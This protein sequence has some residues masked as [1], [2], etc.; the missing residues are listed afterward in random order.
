MSSQGPNSPTL[1]EDI[2]GIGTVSWGAPTNIYSSDN[3][4]ASASAI[5]AT[6]TTH[7]LRAT[8]FDFSIPDGSTIDGIT[9]EI[10]RKSVYGKDVAVNLVIGGS[11]V[12][13]N[14]ADTVNAWPV[15]YTYKQYG[16]ATDKWG[17]TPTVSQINAADFG[18]V[19]SAKVT[20]DKSKRYIYV[21]HIRITVN[22]TPVSYQ[23]RHGV[24]LYQDPGV[25]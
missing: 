17:L 25:V 19:L 15:S 22:Y 11:I 24:I 7:Y 12:G 4:P 13:S 23:P 8:D 6:L 21:D 14:Y 18:C 3:T 16:G 20:A 2:T 10:Q 1:G 5:G 9:V